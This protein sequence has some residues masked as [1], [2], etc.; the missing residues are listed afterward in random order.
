MSLV[1]MLTAAVLSSF[2]FTLRGEQS[3]ANY[4]T[5]N[6]D[7]RE[8]L[9]R[10]SRDSKC[11]LDVTNA[12]TTSV[13]MMI[14]YDTDP[15]HATSVTYE[16]DPVDRSVTREIDGVTTVLASGVS[17]TFA[18]SYYSINNVATS[19]LAEIKQVQLS[20]RMIRTVTTTTTSQYVISAQY[21]LRSKP[22]SH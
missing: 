1:G 3:L 8:L 18:L 11:A 6:G 20:L 22:V 4:N 13:T 14:P 5:M 10:F 16:Y 9:E 12:T 15:T 17:D 2:V 7:A 19:S 21:T